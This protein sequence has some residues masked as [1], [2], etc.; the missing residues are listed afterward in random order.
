MKTVAMGVAL[1]AVAILPVLPAGPAANASMVCCGHYV[2]WA[3][4]HDPADARLAITTEDGNVTLLLTDR[5]VAFQLS[6]RTLH[7]VDGEL[8]ARQS[9][10]DNWW[11]AALGSGV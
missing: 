4:H 2:R 9:L 6:E 1:L 7:K 8:R 11:G 10:G 5:D 3:E